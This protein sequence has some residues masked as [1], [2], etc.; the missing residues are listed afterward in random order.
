MDRHTHKLQKGYS[1]VEV[2][3]A[4]SILLV[5]LVSPLTIIVKS[6]QGAYYAREQTTALFLAQE[7]IEAVVAA[8]NNGIIK[9]VHAGNLAISW[10][11]VLDSENPGI[12]NC[13]D[14]TGCNLDFA[15]GDVTGT[16]VNCS[17]QSN[18]KMVYRSGQ[19][20]PF[21]ASAGGVG[22]A[23]ETEYTRVIKLREVGGGGRDKE[24]EVTST[25]YW[26]ATLFKG[27]S[28]EKVELQTTVF[29]LYD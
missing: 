23:R 8:R 24:V 9:A 15:D 13:F 29:N 7:G 5:V 3:V 22:G 12:S 19:S 1:L 21:A 11:W 6:L 25:V 10:D 2:L 18:C 17:P 27:G 28:L 14:A 16:I 4:I 20:V 26:D